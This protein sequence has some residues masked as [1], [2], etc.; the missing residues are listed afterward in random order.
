MR[1]VPFGVMSDLRKM[2][3]LVSL[4]AAITHNSF[5]GVFSARAVALM[6]HFA[7]YVDEPFIHMGE[8]C[9]E[10]L[11]RE[12]RTLRAILT[13]PW[14]GGAVTSGKGVPVSLAT[15]W[16]V[17]DLLREDHSLMG[18]MHRLIAWGGDTDSVGAIAWGIASARYQDEVL[19][20]FI[21]RDLEQGNPR[22]GT[23]YL[24]EL[25]KSLM[26]RYN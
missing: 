2:S 25:G 20:E 17:A 13:T 12:E 7:L 18:M 26:N 6:S 22:T 19:P 15:V 9:V 5:E 3:E 16:A 8:W 11:P 21:E 1:S 4:Q 10:H 24:Q 23:L 14:R